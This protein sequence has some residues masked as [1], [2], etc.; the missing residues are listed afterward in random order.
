MAPW[1]GFQ[2]TTAGGATDFFLLRTPNACG[3]LPEGGDADGYLA[4]F[5]YSPTIKRGYFVVINAFNKDALRSMR[6][7]IEDELVGLAVAGKRRHAGL[8][9]RLT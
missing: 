3:C 7:V 9:A 8:M 2:K 6:G 1:S 5:A 4:H